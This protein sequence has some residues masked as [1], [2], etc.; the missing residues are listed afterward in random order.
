[1]DSSVESHPGKDVLD[2]VI[3]ISTDIRVDMSHRISL[4]YIG[5]R[6]YRNRNSTF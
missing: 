4:G 3:S 1:M 2:L 5:R 6:Y